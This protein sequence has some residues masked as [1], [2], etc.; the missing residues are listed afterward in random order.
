MAK[1]PTFQ[2]ATYQQAKAK[3]KKNT[4][5]QLISS[6]HKKHPLH[7]FYARGTIVYPP[8]QAFLL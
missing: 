3:R 8:K 6:A 2:P 4:A 1:Q 7:K 5:Q